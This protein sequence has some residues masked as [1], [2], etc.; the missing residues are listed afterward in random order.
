MLVVVAIMMVLVAAAATRMRPAAE[1]RRIRE[2]ARALNVYL[3]SARNRAME[4]GRPCGV[5]LHRF[6]GATAAVMN[7]DQCEVPPS[8][9][10]QQLGSVAQVQAPSGAI[11]VSFYTDA[12]GSTSEQLPGAMVRPND[13]IQFGF[14][15]PMYYIVSNVN[16]TIDANGFLANVSSVTVAL[17]NPAAGQPVP[18]ST[19]ALT[20]PY[21]IFRAPVKSAATPLQLPASTVVD[22]TPSGIDGAATPFDTFDPPSG[23]PNQGRDVAILFSPSGSVYGLYYVGGTSTFVTQPIFLLVGKRERVGA[24]APIATD[25]ATWPNWADLGNVWLVIN[26]QTGLVSSGE[27]AAVDMSTGSWTNSSN[28]P[29]LIN[30]A[31]VLARDSQGLGGK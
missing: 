1:A 21:R 31:R 27:N 30:T 13:L 20:L 7:L 8:Y 12:T 4:T 17:Y 28:W 2:T 6:A 10:G 9:A 14:Q 24:S 25:Q 29:G 19:T 11:T 16:G 5:I 23:N 3:G 26:P 15:G 22:L 18:W